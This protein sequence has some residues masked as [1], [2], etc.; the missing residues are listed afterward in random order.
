MTAACLKKM[1]RHSNRKAS[2]SPKARPAK[3]GGV[4]AGVAAAA[5][6]ATGSA[7]VTGRHFRAM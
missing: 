1:A 4:A 7:M 3:V 6:A 5:A 2:N